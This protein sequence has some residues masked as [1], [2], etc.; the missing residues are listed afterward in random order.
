MV[1]ITAD[2]SPGDVLHEKRPGTDLIGQGK[3][4]VDHLC[5]FFYFFIFPLMIARVD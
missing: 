1:H 4:I 3:T 5:S 2:P